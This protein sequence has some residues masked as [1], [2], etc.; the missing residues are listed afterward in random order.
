MEEQWFLHEIEGNDARHVSFG[1]TGVIHFD[2]FSGMSRLTRI[3]AS[4]RG[5]GFWQGLFRS[6]STGQ[7]F[8]RL[9][10]AISQR[11]SMGSAAKLLLV[12]LIA[13][14]KHFIYSVPQSLRFEKIDE[15]DV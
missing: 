9:L 13:F 7:F 1:K 11:D 2:R 10:F 12:S 5:V 15:E 6:P 8:R 4:A 14:P 3:L